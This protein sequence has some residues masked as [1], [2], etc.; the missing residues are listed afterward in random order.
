MRITPTGIAG[1]LY[2]QQLYPFLYASET[3]IDNID[4]LLYMG[5][6]GENVPNAISLG[7]LVDDEE[8]IESQ[9]LQLASVIA[10]VPEDTIA[11]LED[12]FEKPTKEL[13]AGKAVFDGHNPVI[14]SRLEQLKPGVLYPIRNANLTQFTCS[15]CRSLV[16]GHECIGIVPDPRNE[17]AFVPVL[18]TS[19][20]IHHLEK[21][22]EEAEKRLSRC[23]L[24]GSLLQSL[25]DQ[26]QDN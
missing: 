13:R 12:A 15:F 17:G 21:H 16:S 1:E 14:T 25:R 18:V 10:D 26:N 5:H 24:F 19:A 6:L 9:V 4:F 11:L 7:F 8:G 20:V 2:W 23:A 3:D 22:S